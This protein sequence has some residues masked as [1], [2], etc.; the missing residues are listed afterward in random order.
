MWIQTQNL[1]EILE[2]KRIKLLEVDDDVK[3]LAK[4]DRETVTLGVYPK[5][6]ADSVVEDLKDFIRFRDGMYVMPKEWED[7]DE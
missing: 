6:Q 4:L 1:R 3:I 5:E 2:V 7:E